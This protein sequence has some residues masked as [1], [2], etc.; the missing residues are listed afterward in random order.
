MLTQR[1]NQRFIRSAC[2]VLALLLILTTPALA[3]FT[4]SNGQAARLVLGQVDF[5]NV[6]ADTTQYMMN[7]PSAVAV[8]S[9]TRKVFVADTANCRVLRFASIYALNNGATAEAVLGQPNFT[10]KTYRTTQYG[11]S[12]PRSVFVDSGGRLWVVDTDNNRV[13]RFDH[14]ATLSNG[15]N[16]NGVL[17]QPN[18]TT[19]DNY[20][21]NQYGLSGPIGVFVDASGRLWVGDSFNNRVLRFNN[22]ATKANGAAADGVLG[23]PN[24]TSRG[25][26]TSQKSMS[27]PLALAVDASGRLWLAD[28]NNNRVLR[29]DNAAT[30][31]NGANADGVLGQR[32]FTSSS[33]FTTRAGMGGTTGV[34]IDIANGRLYVS[35]YGNNRILVFNGAAGLANGA[36]ASYVLGQKDFTTGTANTGG[37]SATTLAEPNNIFYDQAAK[38]LWVADTYNNRVLVYGSPFTTISSTSTAAYDGWVL[39]SA[40]ASHVGGSLGATGT[41]RLGDNAS[42]R[43]F[44][45]ILSFNTAALP[46]NA[47]I[48]SVTLKIKKAG[49]LGTDPLTSN[50]LGALLADIKKGSFGASALELGDFQATASAS[51]IGHFTAIGNGWYQVVL[52]ASKFTDVNLSGLTQFRLRF[53]TASNNNHVSDYDSFYAGDATTATDRPVLTVQYY[54][55]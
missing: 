34:A 20:F 36:S 54:L 40:A 38:V 47:V 4:P 1:H 42:N 43:Q 21:T 10:S 51:A 9:A 50:A 11:M 37:V 22:A 30:K 7:N 25:Y 52:P 19:K 48:H 35:D 28:S 46:D 24:F 41:L 44:R 29:F 15:A 14:A 55:P 23:Q 6:G 31:A 53:S 12:Y 18:F 17:G 49:A 16:A 8:D 45:S 13:L 39:E 2:I 33:Y 3:A 27:Y 32:N 5:D 26:A